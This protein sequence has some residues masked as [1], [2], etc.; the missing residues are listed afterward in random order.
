MTLQPD[1][2]DG[3]PSGA[4][5]HVLLFNSVAE[6]LILV[7]ARGPRNEVYVRRVGDAGY[8]RIGPA[9]SDES[10][11]SVVTTSAAPLVYLHVVKQKPHIRGVFQDFVGILRIDLQDQSKVGQV[12]I[13][14]EGA[15]GH[16]TRLLGASAD[17]KQLYCTL[18]LRR[19]LGATKGRIEHV[20]CRV[21]V[22]AGHTTVIDHLH[23][24]FF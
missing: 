3:V 13:L 24:T 15:T 16:V 5:P 19:Q 12:D 21:E 11:E 8:S 18:G 14:P 20:I 22:D 4:N 2:V 9:G 23:R 17:G 6:M 1:S 7:A 10:I